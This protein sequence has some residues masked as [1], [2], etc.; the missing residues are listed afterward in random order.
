MKSYFQMM[1]AYNRWAN[2]RLYD[3]AAGLPDELYRKDIGLFFKSLHGTLNHLVV[4]DRI[5]MHLDG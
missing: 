4:T 2:G 3:A 5:W 1:A